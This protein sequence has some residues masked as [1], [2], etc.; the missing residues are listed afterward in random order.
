MIIPNIQDKLIQIAISHFSEKGYIT[1]SSTYT[2]KNLYLYVKEDIYS[3]ENTWNVFF[4][5]QDARFTVRRRN[6]FDQ[7]FFIEL[8]EN[9]KYL[10]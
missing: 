7:L 5:V 9:R 10:L 6:L 1:F 4:F 8:T 2:K 3:Q